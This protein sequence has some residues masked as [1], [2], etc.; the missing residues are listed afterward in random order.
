MFVDFDETFLL[1]I[2]HKTIYLKQ[3]PCAVSLFWRIQPR[4]IRLI[5]SAKAPCCV[6]RSGWLGNYYIPKPATHHSLSPSQVS[7][8][9]GQSEVSVTANLEV[10]ST[11]RFSEVY[12]SASAFGRKIE[13][14]SQLKYCSLVCWL[15]LLQYISISLW[16]VLASDKTPN[17]IRGVCQSHPSFRRI[18]LETGGAGCSAFYKHNKDWW[19]EDSPE[20]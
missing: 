3:R 13:I 15:L 7:W 10:K 11:M 2:Y 6:G 19:R 14:P 16:D 17:D 18:I 12:E 20:S 8:W 5:R 4:I 1:S 9:T